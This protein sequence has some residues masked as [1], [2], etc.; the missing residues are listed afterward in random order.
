ME[1]FSNGD[2]Q[3]V[4]EHCLRLPGDGKKFN[5]EVC[6]ISYRKDREAL[7]AIMDQGYKKAQ[8]AVCQSLMVPCQEEFL[9]P[10]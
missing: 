9:F 3:F 2:D 1:I 8:R 7:E 5:D 4:L 6:A 10:D